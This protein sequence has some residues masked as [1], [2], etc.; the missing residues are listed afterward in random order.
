MPPRLPAAPLRT[1]LLVAIA[2]APAAGLLAPAGAAVEAPVAPCLAPVE[3]PGQGPSCPVDGG[4]VVPLRG[5]GAVYTHGPDAPM[6]HTPEV[7]GPFAAPVPPAC[8]EASEPHQRVLYA[9]AADRPDRYA[10]L[11]PALRALVLEANGHLAQTARPFLVDVRYKVLCTEEGLVRVDRVVLPTPAAA[12]SFSTLVSDLQEQGYADALAK[13]WVHYDDHVA[14]F[15]G[16]GTVL[17]DDA[18]GPGNAN[19]GGPSYAVTYGH[20]S[21]GLMMHESAHTMGAAQ[22]SAP[23]GTGAWHCNDG[24][25]VLCYADGGPASAYDPS[26]CA[27]R[28][29]AV[30]AFDCNLDDYFHPDPPAG[31]YLATHWNLGS[32]A[33]RFLRVVP[34]ADAALGRAGP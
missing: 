22:P 27:G 1:V 26:A 32:P 17:L 8:V 7:Y 3:V 16:Q 25:D 33:N 12:T 20:L 34:L 24:V 19:N 2:L 21:V 14:G 6:R 18:P 15:G 31:S 4:W 29:S 23:H 10:T 11:L 5:G 9:V 30:M 13:H 28:N